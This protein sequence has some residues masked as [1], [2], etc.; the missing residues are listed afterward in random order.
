MTFVMERASRCW[1]S[2]SKDAMRCR[3]EALVARSG[4][5]DA[6]WMAGCDEQ[7]HSTMARAAVLANR[8]R[9]IGLAP[10]VVLRC[11]DYKQALAASLSGTTRHEDAHP[12]AGHSC[13]RQP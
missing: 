9:I 3:T 13:A 12:A 7:P 5:A 10:M 1:G 11:G 4:S 8:E 2:D 6:R